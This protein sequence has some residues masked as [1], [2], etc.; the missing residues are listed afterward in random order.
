MD[1]TRDPGLG[2]YGHMDAAHVRRV[3]LQAARMSHTAMKAH[4]AWL[5]AGEVFRVGPQIGM[6]LCIHAGFDP[7][8]CVRALTAH[9]PDPSGESP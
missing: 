3:L 2:D 8:D 6:N 5:F 4:P 7:F 9:R 1:H